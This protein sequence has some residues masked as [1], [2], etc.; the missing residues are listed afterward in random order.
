MD[1]AL[2]P[3]SELPPD[4]YVIQTFRECV[5]PDGMVSV[6][7]SAIKEIPLSF[8]IPP[9]LELVQVQLAVQLPPGVM[10]SPECEIIKPP[11]EM[12]PLPHVSSICFLVQ[13]NKL[14]SRVHIL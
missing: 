5:L 7:L 14:L 4:V 1:I 6:E 13:S 3:F 12:P 11:K 10:I 9:G 8:P 2:E